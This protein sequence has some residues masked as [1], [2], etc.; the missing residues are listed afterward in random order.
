MNK[1]IT[2]VVDARSVPHRTLV[3]G[4]KVPLFP[5]ETSYCTAKGQAE[6]IKLIKSNAGNSRLVM[7]VV[8]RIK[9]SANKLSDVKATVLH[10]S[11]SQIKGVV[12][13]VDMDC[14][15]PQAYLAAVK[16]LFRS[17]REPENRPFTRVQHA[18]AVT[19]R[20]W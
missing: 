4:E 14:T 20:W 18:E 9:D 13:L 8:P 17:I 15:D 7:A 16:P 11:A 5:T 2:L 6:L 1:G 3:G 19:Q 12:I 10:Y